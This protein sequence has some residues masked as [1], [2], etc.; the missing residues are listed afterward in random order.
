VWD[1]DVL[2]SEKAEACFVLPLREAAAHFDCRNARS[3]EAEMGGS[4]DGT[5]IRALTCLQTW[6]I[7]FLP[8]FSKQ[9]G[10]LLQQSV[11]FSAEETIRRCPR[12]ASRC[13]FFSSRSWGA[14]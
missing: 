8:F 7:G 3:A 5:L 1:I 14:C 10:K 9:G 6:G 12:Q 13:F 4:N 2:M 11:G